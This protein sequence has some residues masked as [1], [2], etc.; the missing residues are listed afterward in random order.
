MDSNPILNCIGRVA[1]VTTQKKLQ[2]GIEVRL[3]G[4]EPRTNGLKVRCSTD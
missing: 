2:V 4:L 1:K 3:L